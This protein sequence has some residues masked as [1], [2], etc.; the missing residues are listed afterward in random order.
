MSSPVVP[1]FPGTA[2]WNA[3]VFGGPGSTVGSDI[4]YPALRLIRVIRPGHGPQSEI[5]T[6]ALACLNALLDAWNTERLTIPCVLGRTFQV[7]SGQQSYTIGPTGQWLLEERPQRIEAASLIRNQ[8]GGSPIEIPLKILIL[9]EW[10]AIPVKAIQSS[11]PQSLYYEPSL[12]LGNGTVYVYPVPTEANDIV[13]HL[14]NQ[15]KQFESLSDQF[16]LPQG[17]LKALQYSLAVEL[18]PRYENSVLSPLVIDTAVKSKAQIKS[19]NVVPLPLRCDEALVA[20][21][22]GFDWRTGR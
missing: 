3:G 12:N 9:D 15:L 19:M 6:E 22:G 4:I 1:A 2:P 14:W 8:S 18:A 21:R 20:R 16:V 5:L 10:Q 17:Y 13:L 11:I 7:V